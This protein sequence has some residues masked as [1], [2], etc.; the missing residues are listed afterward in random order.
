MVE[1][2]P[3]RC[4]LPCKSISAVAVEKRR[5]TPHCSWQLQPCRLLANRWRAGRCALQLRETPLG[6]ARLQG[7]SAA[8]EPL[9][10]ERCH[11]GPPLLC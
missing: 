11:E 4:L 2:S 8:S 1:M 6:P 5:H 3:D 9:R 7:V 10:G